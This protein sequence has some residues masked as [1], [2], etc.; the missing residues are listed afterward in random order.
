[1]YLFAFLQS[2]LTLKARRAQP[3]RYTQRCIYTVVFFFPPSPRCEMPAFQPTVYRWPLFRWGCALTCGLHSSRIQWG[4]HFMG[5]TN[6]SGI[7][8]QSGKVMDDGDYSVLSRCLFMEV[9]F[10]LCW[11]CHVCMCG[12]SGGVVCLNHWSKHILG[13]CIENRFQIWAIL[14]LLNLS[15]YPLELQLQKGLCCT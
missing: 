13:S 6:N 15:C 1:M 4:F 12:F 9:N 8:K 3:L 14:L 11:G 5:Y 10:I 7:I 2:L